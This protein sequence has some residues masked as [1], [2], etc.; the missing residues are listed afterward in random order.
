MCGDE[1]VIDPDGAGPAEPFEVDD[2]T[3][4]TRSLRGSAVL[5][6]EWRPGSTLF[7]VW[8]QQREMEDARG[9][10]RFRR[11][12]RELGRARP[13]NVF[14]VKATWWLNP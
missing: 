8:Q 12:L 7:L 13:D 11:D 10:L 5:R 4:T 9:D 6:W 14:V 1:I 3:F 2:E